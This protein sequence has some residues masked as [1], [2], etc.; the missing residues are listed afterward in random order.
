MK[1]PDKTD[2]AIAKIRCG[3][4]RE[5]SQLQFRAVY[6]TFGRPFKGSEQVKQR[7]FSRSGLAH[8]AHHLSL[9]YPEGQIFKEHQ[10]GRPRSKHFRQAFRSENHVLINWMQALSPRTQCARA[11]MA[12]VLRFAP[13]EEHRGRLGPKMAHE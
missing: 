6:V 8:D 3:L 10:I 11:I 13:L 9:C 4:V 12:S 7:T 5:R 2:F 1:L